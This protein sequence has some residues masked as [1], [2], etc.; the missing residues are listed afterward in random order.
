MTANEKLILP[1]DLVEKLQRHFNVAQSATR[2]NQFFMELLQYLRALRSHQKAIEYIELQPIE[3]SPTDNAIY[4]WQRLKRY[5]RFVIDNEKP[6]YTPGLPFSSHH[7]FREWFNEH[8]TEDTSLDETREKWTGFDLISPNPDPS[9][10][11]N[12]HYN[13]TPSPD[14]NFENYLDAKND[15][16]MMRK[17]HEWLLNNLTERKIEAHLTLDDS[18]PTISYEGKTVTMPTLHV[19]LSEDILLYA[20]NH[21]GKT[22]TRR[23]LAKEY[24]TVERANLK[25]VFKA[26][27]F[28]GALKPFAT[29]KT[30]SIELRPKAILTESE[31]KA[32]EVVA[33]SS[34]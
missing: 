9:P 10:D 31:I 34:D 8:S 17:L 13:P 22:V 16:Y 26:N 6:P 18:I 28:M 5:I 33:I 19:G 20:Y 12:P 14:Y 7:S 32:I 30:N 3:S 27:I 2:A 24:S 21:I 25:Q 29:I 4:Y 23:E 11:I 15:Q 1:D